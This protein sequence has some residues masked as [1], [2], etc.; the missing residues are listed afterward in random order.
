MNNAQRYAARRGYTLLE[1]PKK[2]LIEL[3]EIVEHFAA[4]EERVAEEHKDANQDHQ[5]IWCDIALK[6]GRAWYPLSI[7]GLYLSA[8]FV[9]TQLRYLCKEDPHMSLLSPSVQVAFMALG[10][11]LWLEM[12]PEDHRSF[13]GAEFIQEQKE[14]L[15]LL[16]STLITKQQIDERLFDIMPR[17]AGSDN[18]DFFFQFISAIA[19]QFGLLLERENSQ[20]NKTLQ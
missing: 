11:L 3:Q 13:G 14:R 17:I 4:I 8:Q 7:L 10:L 15:V 12:H 5:W 19:A 18:P 1:T 16:I 9:K 20:Y 2:V 6:E